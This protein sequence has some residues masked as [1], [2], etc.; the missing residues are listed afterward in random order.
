MKPAQYEMLDSPMLLYIVT[1]FSSLFAK[2]GSFCSHA[3]YETGVLSSQ[4]K[5]EKE[6]RRH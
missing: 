4:L 3:V 2:F 1:Q 5:M 6:I